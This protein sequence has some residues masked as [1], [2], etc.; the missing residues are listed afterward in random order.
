LEGKQEAMFVN[1]FVFRSQVFFFILIAGVFG[2]R[3]LDFWNIVQ[4]APSPPHGLGKAWA[5]ARG[6]GPKKLFAFKRG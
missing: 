5:F 1:D 3:Q 2:L 6:H 4:S